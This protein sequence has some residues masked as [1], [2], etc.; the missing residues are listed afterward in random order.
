MANSF[1]DSEID[2]NEYSN[3]NNDIPSVAF[4]DLSQNLYV[5]SGSFNM[6]YDSSNKLYDSNWGK[7]VN[8]DTTIGL[9]NNQNYYSL[10]LNRDIILIGSINVGAYTGYYGGNIEYSQYSYQGFIIG[11]YCTLDLNGH[12]IIVGNPNGYAS[13]ECRGV[14]NDSQNTGTLVLTNTAN[15]YNTF[16]IEDVYHEKRIPYTYFTNDNIFA[17]YRCAYWTCN[18]RIESGANVY[19][20]YNMDLGGN[21]D[22]SS[23]GDLHILGKDD[24]LIILQEGFIV[25]NIS[26]NTKVSNISTI[27]QDILNQ[28]IHYEAIDSK[29]IFGNFKLHFEYSGLNADLDSNSYAFYISPYYEIYL[30]NSVVELNQHLVFMPGT[31]L[32]ADNQSI[33]KFSYN[34]FSKQEGFSKYIPLLAKS[35]T[36]PDKCW[37]SVGGLTFMDTLYDMDDLQPTLRKLTKT[38]RES[39]IFGKEITVYLN[40]EGYSCY[41]YQNDNIREN[42]WNNLEPAYADLYCKIEFIGQTYEQYGNIEFGGLINIYN[43]DSFVLNYKNAI[44]NNIKITLYS[45][46]FKTDWC[47]IIGGSGATLS[48][49]CD[50][51]IY[52]D[53]TGYY[54]YPL[55]SNGYVLFN[56]QNPLEI[57]NVTDKYVYDFNSKTIFNE[58]NKLETYCWIF[59]NDSMD[60]L[61]FCSSLESTNSLNGS[62]RRVNSTI[63]ADNSYKGEINYNGNSYIMWHGAYIMYDVSQSGYY[64]G[65]F[66]DNTMYSGY[67]Y[68]KFDYL[69]TTGNYELK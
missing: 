10:K 19:G 30:Y 66:F 40:M 21:G 8:G 61:A 6:Y 64:L 17:M 58:S 39:L 15:L 1:T 31:Y 67:L 59:D 24:G 56:P 48:D 22:E 16:I 69:S 38:Y 7:L 13:I 9:T 34:L 29:V 18:T 36:V 65:K 5:Y 68:G 14:L 45:S 52:R 12:D 23:H 3:Y 55:I 60:N 4:N 51:N 62:F 35:V 27:T 33:L 49:R 11:N 43:V 37:Q 25:R 47:R 26:T 54:N 28:K 41:I 57:C 32:Y 20:I 2:K 53:V 50:A 63:N 42:L 46:T 44:N